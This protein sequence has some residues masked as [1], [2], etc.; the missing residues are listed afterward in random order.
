[1]TTKLTLTV[2]KSVIEKA[3]KYAKGTQRSLS[4][5][6]QKYLES[7]VEESDKSELS[8]KIKKL[9]GSLKLPENFDYDKALDDY[10]KEKYDL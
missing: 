3:K 1:M 2:E 9:A 5:M 6:V 7:L 10:Y 4:E 8:P